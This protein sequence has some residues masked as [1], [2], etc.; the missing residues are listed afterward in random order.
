MTRHRHPRTKAA[1]V[2]AGSSRSSPRCRKRWAARSPRPP[3]V[4]RV[5]AAPA[6]PRAR[7][8]CAPWFPSCRMGRGGRGAAGCLGPAGRPPLGPARARLL[9]AGRPAFRAAEQRG[10]RGGHARP[11]QDRAPRGPAPVAG[12]RP[13]PGP[14]RGA[15]LWVPD[16]RR[17]RLAARRECGN[18]GGGE[19]HGP[20]SAARCGHLLRAPAP[21][22]AQAGWMPGR[23]G[24]CRRAAAGGG[25]VRSG[26]GAVGGRFREAGA[27]AAAGA[28]ARC[29]GQGP[30]W[31]R[32]VSGEPPGAI[33]RPSS[34]LG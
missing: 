13:V 29:S 12:L 2:A 26:R 33:A 1:S 6:N 8:P 32:E 7:Q 15:P 5:R 3:P 22:L 9:V 4:S 23:G 16:G 20:E 30:P 25:R 10:P 19:A 14:G 17:D 18:G 27:A 21:R 28:A 31:I 11:V 34:S 24:L